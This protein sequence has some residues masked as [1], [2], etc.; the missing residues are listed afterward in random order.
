MFTITS[1]ETVGDVAATAELSLLPV[2]GDAH[3]QRTRGGM[4]NDGFSGLLSALA[5]SMPLT[6]FAQVSIYNQML[7]TEVASS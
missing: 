3:V 4:L 5:G 1:V 7:N 6:T 2:E